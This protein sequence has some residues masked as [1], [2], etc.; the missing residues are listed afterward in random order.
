MKKVIRYCQ[1]RSESVKFCPH[2]L[3][4][5]SERWKPYIKKRKGLSPSLRLSLSWALKR[6][7]TCGWYL[8][9]NQAGGQG[10]IQLDILEC[11]PDGQLEDVQ[12]LVLEGLH[13]GVDNQVCS[14]SRVADQHHFDV[15][16]DPACHLN[17]DRDPA[18]HFEADPGS[19]FHFDADQDP[20]FQINDKKNW[21]SA[22]I[23]S[24]SI[25]FGLS[26]ANWCGSGSNLSLFCGS[27]WIR[28]RNT[29]WNKASLSRC[30]HNFCP[31]PYSRT[32]KVGKSRFL[33]ESG[34]ASA[35]L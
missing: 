11:A 34:S 20:S 8:G 17:T 14:E 18:C 13:L 21:E 25:H 9:R 30:S 23:G 2:F 32:I 26:S 22:Q 29:V 31:M 3:E 4:K 12:L 6:K 24:Y 7:T 33:F 28:I 27:M 35:G 16:P 19:T 10:G 1:R 15:D 5:I